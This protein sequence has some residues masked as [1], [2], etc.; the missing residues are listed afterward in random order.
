MKAAYINHYTIVLQ[1]PTKS[2]SET[3]YK[4][5]HTQH[6]RRT[7]S[8][9][10][11][12]TE[13]TTKKNSSRIHNHSAIAVR[14]LCLYCTIHSLLFVFYFDTLLLV[15]MYKIGSTVFIFFRKQ[16]K[17]VDLPT[18]FLTYRYPLF[19]SD[20]TSIPFLRNNAAVTPVPVTF[21]PEN[22]PS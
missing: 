7:K 18:P 21:F 6:T 2:L 20:S 5:L 3:R 14:L 22:V 19:C 1:I 8:Q 15:F 13:R 17:G 9:D 4:Y 11:L 10:A 16:Q 12:L